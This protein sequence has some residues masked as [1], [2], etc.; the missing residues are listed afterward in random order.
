MQTIYLDHAATSWPKPPAVRSAVADALDAIGNPGRSGHRLSLQAARLVYAARQELS[1]LLGIPD[2]Q[3]LVFTLNATDALNMAIKGLVRPGDHVITTCFDHNSVLRPLAGL[4]RQGRIELTVLTPDDGLCLRPEQFEQALRPHTSLVAV[5]HASNVTGALLDVAGLGASCR[6]QGV[7]LLVDASQTLGSLPF[8]LSA[9]QPD[10]LAA[11]GHK[12]LL[13]PQ[14][15]GFLYVRPGVDLN[16]WR[17]GGTGSSSHEIWQPEFMPD[18]LEAGTPN[19]PGLAGLAASARWLRQQ[20]VAAVR[21]HELELTE[22]LRAGLAGIP[23]L[24]LLGPG[25]E[26]GVGVV[27]ISLADWDPSDLAVALEDGYGVLTRPGLHCAPLAHQAI[28]TFPT[29]TVRLSVGYCTTAAEIDQTVAALQHL[30][31]HQ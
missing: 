7:K 31:R 23:G 2:A 22:R 21:E 24:K 18:R 10:C 26:R 30:S 6:A 16:F 19:T 8:D 20:G 17:E 1:Q 9:V 25:G 5:S 15:T 4:Q 12:G 29:G 28:G 14:G 3:Q 11:S 13:G 27:S